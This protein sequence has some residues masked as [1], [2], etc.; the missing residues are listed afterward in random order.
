MENM[1]GKY[2]IKDLEALSGIK[3]HTLRIWE[4][5]YGILQP[6]RT[7]T[8][9]RLYSNEDLKVILNVSALNKHG[10]KISKIACLN[11]REL[12]EAVKQ[13]TISSGDTDSLIDGLIVAM[14]DLDEALFNRIFSVNTINEGFEKTIS[15]VVF[16]F[17]RKIGV[18]WQTDSINPAQEHFITNLVRQKLIMAIDAAKSLTSTKQKKI[19]FYLPEGEL[20][21]LSLLFYTYLAKT[22]GHT[23]FYLGQSVPLTDL[24]KIA[25]ISNCDM[26]VSVITQPLSEKSLN[27]YFVQL[28]KI[29][30]ELPFCISGYQAVN[31]AGKLPK[32]LHLFKTP[33][34]FVKHI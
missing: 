15:E 2:S 3:A 34:D 8:N 23:T 33:T 10:L 25:E 24:I 30:P 21:E 28:S 22:K 9:I 1:T 29:L 11:K 7:D 16:P 6:E 13:L 12:N 17:L 20:H 32:N 5:R 18:M 27:S 26:A 19:V 4:Q 31:Y 14:V